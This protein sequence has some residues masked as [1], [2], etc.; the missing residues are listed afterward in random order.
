MKTA[1]I[2]IAA[3]LALS[4][5]GGGSSSIASSTAVSSSTA[6]SVNTA[7]PSS[8]TV[9]LPVSMQNST[10]LNSLP[11]SIDGGIASL[12]GAQP[13][14]NGVFTTI[15][16][17]M[18]NTNQCQNIDHVLVD[19]GSVGLRL[20]AQSAGGELSLP[21]PAVTSSL[22][23]AVY[24]CTQFADGYSWGSMNQAQVNLGGETPVTL[25]VQVIGAR[26]DL[27][28]A[29]CI[30]NAT[31]QKAENNLSTL[32]SNGIIGIGA[33]TQDCGPSCYPQPYYYCS[34]ANCSYPSAPPPLSEQVENP[35]TALKQDNNGSIL[36]LPSV[37]STGASNV[38]G[39]LLLGIN[40]QSNNQIPGTAPLLMLDINGQLGGATW[41][42]GTL[43]TF[44]TSYFDSGTSVL[45]IGASLIPSCSSGDGFDCPASQIS[46][47]AQVFAASG[48]SSP[49]PSFRLDIGNADQLF[50][51]FPTNY[52]FAN[53]GAAAPDN[54]TLVLGLPFFYGHEV[55]LSITSA[56][57]NAEISY[58]N[59]P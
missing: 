52:A 10:A 32:A 13:Y 20:L 7:N 39:Q 8:N 9:T 42:N 4:A 45:E 18:P 49:A 57:N 6:G 43:N 34:S 19:T 5:C 23:T 29:S 51:S 11:L 55:A 14:I 53:L 50:A 46:G 25:P 58:W 24:E 16:V 12:R 38:S 31:V 22:G 48:T 37:S 47:T 3:C 35:I 27:T 30:Q 56:H 44:S 17:C 21:L 15:T 33:F 28:P 59:V 40:T 36:I 41:S 54:N 2:I 26:T 1:L